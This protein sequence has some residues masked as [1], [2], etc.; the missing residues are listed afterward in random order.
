MLITV[1]DPMGCPIMTKG[2][3][4]HFFEE[5]NKVMVHNKYLY[6]GKIDILGVFKIERK[7][8]IKKV[9]NVNIENVVGSV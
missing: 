2:V 1:S 3:Y 4:F 8:S 9:Q 7:E 5:V 6:S